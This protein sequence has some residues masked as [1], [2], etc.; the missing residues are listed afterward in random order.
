MI[1]MSAVNYSTSDQQKSALLG[2]Y[3]D[4]SGSGILNPCTSHKY[5]ARGVLRLL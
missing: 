3:R 4:R 1:Q 2:K 5:L